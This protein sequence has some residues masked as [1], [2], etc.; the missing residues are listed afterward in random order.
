MKKVHDVAIIGGGIIG[1]SI[2]YEL[3]RYKLDLILLE[4]N[5]VLANETSLGNTGLIHGGFDPDPSKKNE[6]WMNVEGNKKWVN[7]WFKHLQFPRVKIDSLITAFNDEEMEH[8]HMLYERGLINKVRKED[9]QI[10]SKEE[11]IKK[12]PNINKDVKGALLCTSS[13]AIA[14]VEATKALI[15]AAMQNGME[16]AKNAKVVSIKKLKVFLEIKTEDNR[17]FYAKKIVNAAGHYADVL[18]NENGFD[19][20]KQTTRRGEY[21]VLDKYTPNLVNSVVFKVPTIHGK[22]VVVAPTLDG[23][24]IVGPTA[25]E[26]VPKEDTRLVTREKY[27]Y[28]GKVGTDLIPDIKLERTIMTLSG[29]RPIDIETDD[30]VIR[31]SKNDSDFILA[32]GMQSPGLSSAP[33]IASEIAKLLNVKLEPKPDFKPDFTQLV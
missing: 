20:F 24:Y 14:P 2:A 23:H 11:V 7:E 13:W 1:A 33:V 19:D 27:D 29:S 26:N 16:L 22:G 18:A 10:L 6:P 25:E 9:M 3:A 15:G 28:I 30:F 12:E 5:P 4:K 8:V 17:V 31:P 21:R 32:A